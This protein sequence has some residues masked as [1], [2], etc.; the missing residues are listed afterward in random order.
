MLVIPLVPLPS[1]ANGTCMLAVRTEAG[2]TDESGRSLAGV[3]VEVE[4]GKVVSCAAKVDQSPP[5]WALGS[6]ETWLDVVMDG[7]LEHL[8]FGGARPQLAMNLVNGL[9]F[10]LFGL[11][12]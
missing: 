6:A 12:D 9:H 1:G 2:E 3:T 8:R 11:I 10:A 7:G 4:R 5:T